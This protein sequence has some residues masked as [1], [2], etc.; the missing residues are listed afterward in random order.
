M[1]MFIEIANLVIIVRVRGSPT[2]LDLKKQI[3]TRPVSY[4][5]DKARPTERLLD[6]QTPSPVELT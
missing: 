5:R 4:K 2:C 1:S 3:A 6:W